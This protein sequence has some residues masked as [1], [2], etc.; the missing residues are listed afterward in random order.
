[1]KY[2][3]IFL[4]RYWLLVLVIPAIGIPGYSFFSNFSEISDFTF[5]QISY[6]VGR[7]LLPGILIFV[8]VSLM[9]AVVYIFA[10]LIFIHQMIKHF[11]FWSFKVAFIIISIFFL[12]TPFSVWHLVH[13]PVNLP[14]R[15]FVFPV[16][17]VSSI[18]WAIAVVNRKEYESL[19]I[20]TV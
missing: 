9:L 14:F 20:R 13:G 16:Y 5:S 2:T 8:A 4:L 15:T 1:M 7:Y 12:A 10:S 18:F 19:K 3:F 17:M 11:Q 6:E